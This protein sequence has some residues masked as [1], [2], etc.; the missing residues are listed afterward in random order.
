MSEQTVLNIVHFNDVYRVTPQKYTPNPSETIDVTQFAW[1]VDQLRGKWEKAADGSPGGLVL[2]SGDVFSPS[3]ESSVTR[4]SH[5]VPVLNE[6]GIDVSVTGNHDFDFGYPHLSTLVKD[7]TFPW[8]LSNIIDTT[9][10]RVPAALKEYF[11]LER[12]GVRVGFIGLVEK[13][14]IATVAS[15]PA[16]FEYQSMEETGLRLS[17]ELRGQ[18]GCDIVIALTHCRLPNDIP[19]AKKLF[20]FTPAHQKAHPIADEHGVD[21]L[22][23]GHDHLYYVSKGV[24]GWEDFDVNEPVLGAEEDQ[25]DILVIKSG[26]DFRDISDLEL[27]LEDTKPGSVRKK[28]ISHITGKRHV[29]VP[30]TPRCE[31]VD[32]LVKKLLS[33]VGSTLKAP[34]CT[35]TTMLDL[36]GFHIRTTESAAGNWFADVVRPA[37]DDALLANGGPPADGAFICAGTLRGDSTYGPGVIT[38]GD[39]LEILP[40]EDPAVVIE[41]DGQAIWEALEAGLST[42]PSQE[43]RFPVLS[44]FRVRWDSRRE[45][46]SR[47]LNVSLVLEDKHSRLTFE[48]VQKTPGGRMY[49]IVTREYMADGHDGYVALKKCKR[50][51]DEEAGTLMSSIV[52]KYLM[53]SHFVN[54]LLHSKN[55]TDELGLHPKVL[56]CLVSEL[57]ATKAKLL[58]KTALHRIVQLNPSSHYRSHLGVPGVH[59]M[60]S[61]DVFDGH[62]ARHGL[63]SEYKPAS[64]KGRADLL[65]VSPEIDGRLR[66]VGREQPGATAAVEEET[67]E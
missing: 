26:S 31:R 14:W 42:W 52:R 2:F 44:G 55:R 36:R 41:M 56:A 66:D 61:I 4:G 50:I 5:M 10:G 9:T 21:L 20:A 64:E 49:R 38:L 22:L 54:R 16:E 19:L 28:V 17:R 13:E 65:V 57:P 29:V 25:G 53:G 18:H 48:P 11:V 32:E 34:V 45:P 47:V 60:S 58:W 15:W 37:Y 23:G 30:S 59:H 62:S 24:D 33:S 43:G 8:L 12:C 27:V 6:L 67:A 51:I 7:N 1:I 3:V 63:A 35:S 39:I 46:G 40:F